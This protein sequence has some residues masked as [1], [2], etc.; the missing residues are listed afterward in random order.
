MSLK[1]SKSHGRIGRV[2]FWF[3]LAKGYTM[4]RK[5]RFI[6]SGITLTA[7]GL[8]MRT[9]AMLLGAFITRAVGA[10]GVGLYTVVMTVYSFALTFATS[11]ISLTVTRLVAGAVGEGRECDVGRILRASVIYSICFGFLATSFL[12]WGSDIIGRYILSEARVVSSLKI[13][14]LSLIPAALCSVFSGYFVGVKRVG[15]N[16]AVQV[17]S[18]ISKVVLT[19]VLVTRMAGGGIVKSVV[20][21]C[22]G[23]TLT[24]TISLA[25]IFLEF[26]FDRRRHGNR[27]S[28]GQKGKLREVYRS[29]LPLAVSAYVRSILTTIEHILIPKRLMHRGENNKEAYS[30]YGT[31][32]GMALPLILYP[33]APL[34]S[35][36]GL[37]VPEFAEDMA[38]K[39]E[40]RMSRV[41]SEALNTTL[42]YA[43]FASVL[44]FFFS[45][46]L[47][48]VVYNSY[49]AGKFIAMLAPIVPI[50]FL[51]HVTDGILKGVG[52]QVYS[53]WVN[54]TDSLLSVI[55]VYFLIP[56]MG[57][58]GYAVVIIIMEG[59]NFLLSALRLSKR[60]KIKID[61]LGSALIPTAC[62]ALS[63]TLSD[64]LFVFGGSSAKPLWLTAKILFTT[65]I[66]V[67]LFIYT[68]VTLKR[69]K[70]S[71]RS[72]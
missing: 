71:R 13:L 70:A 27:E 41:A 63:A 47:G 6:K 49:G 53:M 68:K 72:A 37:L 46:E 35:F 39:R 18:Q 26:I 62:A 2:E 33:M 42:V 52:E 10:E 31:L 9:S 45:E 40:G 61:F 23:I 24:E 14:A 29:A 8:A 16:A 34:T 54:I 21:L 59:Y 69:L 32:H 19:L 44:L 48:Y 60:V 4:N 36:S 22:I 50:M 51:D 66:F 67:S 30:S 11:G 28:R 57:I 15:F 65:L 3:V 38:A 20:A 17:L 43:A 5:I 64:I 25:L 55:L 1:R 12:F 7:V 58:A 56:A